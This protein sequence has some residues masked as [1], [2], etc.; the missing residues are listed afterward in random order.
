MWCKLNISPEYSGA[1]NSYPDLLTKAG[2]PQEKVKNIKDKTKYVIKEE[3]QSHLEKTGIKAGDRDHWFKFKITSYADGALILKEDISCKELEDE[4]RKQE[5]E[6]YKTIFKNSI[7]AIVML[8]E[9]GNILDINEKFQ[10]VFGYSLSEVKGKHLDEVMESGR[11]GYSDRGKTREILKGRRV[12]GEI[13]RY[14]KDGGRWEFVAQGTPIVVEDE[15]KGA[16]IA[17]ND[18]TDLK[19]EKLWSDALFKEIPTSIVKIDSQGSIVEINKMFEETFGYAGENARGENLDEILERGEAS[20]V[21]RELT[22]QITGGKI[23]RSEGT[24]Y[25]KGGDPAEFIIKGIPVII[26][27]EVVGAYGIYEDITEQKKAEEELKYLSYHD[28]LTGLYNRSYVM[29]EMKRLNTERQLPLSLIMCDVNCM[30]ITNDAY[31][32]KRGDE[33]LVEVASILR[34]N[35]REED[36]VARWAGDEFLILLPQTDA[37][38]SQKIKARIEEGCENANLDNIPISMG[39]GISTKED[40][41]EAMSEVL[42][43]ADERMYEDK[44]EKTR[45]IE[46]EFLQN[47]LKTLETKSD[48]SRTHYDRV[49]KLAERLGGEINLTD[50]QLKNLSHAATFHDIGM[51]KIPEDVLNKTGDLTEEEW[52]EIKE[53]PERG[54]NIIMATHEFASIAK[55]ILHHHEHWDGGGYPEGLEK[56]EI[57]LMSRIIAIADAYE[58]M[59]SGRSYNEAVSSEEALAEIERCAGKQ[60]DP[61]LAQEFVEMIEEE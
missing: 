25:D 33:L 42:V 2:C 45:S 24:R 19:R 9:K 49:K 54:C 51:I 20:S 10:Q 3:L 5:L 35:T 53:H 8:D 27:D 44:F 11:K 26:D 34:E 30:K 61:C 58:V 48:E 60:F 56:A 6:K 22:R 40:K 55:I 57:P 18:I 21:N 47:M 1:E 43:R 23:I 15:V 4:K 28:T 52:L 17:Y 32:H 41:N 16:Y 12:K 46:Y 36:I 38:D 13:T 50:E 39:L 59:T 37:G 7:S 31:G 14:D 29:E